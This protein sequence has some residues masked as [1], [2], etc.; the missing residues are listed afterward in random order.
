MKSWTTLVAEDRDRLRTIIR[1][2]RRGIINAT[3]IDF[4]H[5]F[6]DEALNAKHRAGYTDWNGDPIHDYQAHI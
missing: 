4:L 6:V 5:L 3:D 2:I 1:D